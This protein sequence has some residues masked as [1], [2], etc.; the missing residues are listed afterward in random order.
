MIER[1]RLPL[2]GVDVGGQHE[3]AIARRGPARC[4]CLIQQAPRVRRVAVQD[5]ATVPVRRRASF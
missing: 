5:H 1:R 4:L 2:V 3:H